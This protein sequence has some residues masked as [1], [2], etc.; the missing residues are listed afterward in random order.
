MVT[1]TMSIAKGKRNPSVLRYRQ[2]PVF[3]SD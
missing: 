3:L 2:R 1:L